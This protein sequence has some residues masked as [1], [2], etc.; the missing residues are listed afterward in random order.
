MIIIPDIHGRKFWKDAVKGREEED[1]VFLGDYL[2]PYSHEGISSEDAYDN[3]I[4][5]VEFKK[6]HPKNVT[7]LIGNHDQHY[8]IPEALEG[9]RYS[10]WSARK[11][12]KVFDENYDIFQLC[13]ERVIGG[14]R[15][16]FSHAGVVKRW[17]DDIFP[18]APDEKICDYLNN[19]Y[20]TKWD[21]LGAYLSYISH[22]RWGPSPFGSCTW[23]DFEEHLEETGEHVADYQIF[24]HTQLAEYPIITDWFADLDV[25]RGFLL[26]EDGVIREMDGTPAIK[27]NELKEKFGN[28]SK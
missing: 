16:L 19:A 3:F 26:G 20:W 13:T 10:H 6:A 7:L 12:F 8:F 2:D 1:I 22:K 14:K 15:Y 5:I 23:A 18:K 28:G 9:S 27:Y 17:K 21:R 24:G 11:Y 4:E 25:R